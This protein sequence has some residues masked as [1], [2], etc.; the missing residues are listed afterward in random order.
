[1]AVKVCQFYRL[2]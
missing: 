2:F 1:M